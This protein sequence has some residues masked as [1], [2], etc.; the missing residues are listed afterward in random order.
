MKPWREDGLVA[1]EEAEG[2]DGLVA[3]GPGGAPGDQ[4]QVELA[5]VVDIE[6]IGGRSKW[7]AKRATW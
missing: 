5:G 2:A 6:L 7:V 1:E 4:V 3:L